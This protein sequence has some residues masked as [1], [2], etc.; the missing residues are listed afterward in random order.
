MAVAHQKPRDLPKTE[1]ET[2][3][4]WPIIAVAAVLPVLFLAMLIGSVL[5]LGDRKQAPQQTA[6]VAQRT[7][8]PAQE[9]GKRL[10]APGQPTGSKQTVAVPSP[11]TVAQISELQPEM[12]PAP[13]PEP[14]PARQ[15]AAAPVSPPAPPADVRRAEA[16]EASA[17]SLS[18][19]PQRLSEHYL[20]M[21]LRD[22]VLEVDL[23]AVPGWSAKLQAAAKDD[24]PTSKPATP[25]APNK[26]SVPRLQGVKPYFDLLAQRPDLSGLPV[27]KGADCQTDKN[28][29]ETMQGLSLTLR[30]LQPG[31]FRR[32]KSTSNEAK[33]EAPI[34]E[35]L[36]HLREGREPG[37]GSKNQL[38]KE[39]MEL[40]RVKLGKLS[41]AMIPTLVQVLQ[42]Q[43]APVRL[44]LV[45]LLAAIKGPVATAALARRALFDLAE[46]VR[47]AAV[48]EL[49]Q[50]SQKEY[51][52]VLLDGL[53]YPWA[54]VADHAADALVALADRDAAPS[55]VA[56]L[57]KPDPCAPVRTKDHKWIVKEL[58]GVNHLRNCFLCHAPSFDRKDPVRG[59]VPTPGERLPVEYYESSRGIF[60][61]ADVT[62]L[63]QDFS[64]VQPVPYHDKW[65]ALQRYDY[66]VREREPTAPEL[67]FW[68]GK[69]AAWYPQRDAVLFALRQLTGKDA[70]DS[71]KDWHQALKG[72]GSVPS[73]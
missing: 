32:S 10:A 67:S 30:F 40:R 42:S 65:P 26:E 29:V 25:A 1:L 13:R 71:A 28:A 9:A 23:D 53:R 48:R 68:A 39:L 7:S 45:K 24:L 36:T 16:T 73:P 55:L 5:G 41:E 11:T 56:L 69:T 22:A 15:V 17:P 2:V 43:R 3:I 54:P 8:P 62:Y 51:R 64:V 18:R 44:E 50:R 59:L 52:Q 31:G 37:E 34:I 27:R 49:K 33:D 19:R 66:L 21:S 12:L 4:H 6:T 58:V 14:E 70:G 60:V 20:A 61:R 47:E 46:D 63:K 35:F 57:D 38:L 72:T